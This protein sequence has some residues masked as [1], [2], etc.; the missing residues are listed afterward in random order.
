M[1]V[2]RLWLQRYFE[3]ELPSIEALSDVL[4]FHAFEI[5]SIENDILD[6]KVTAN[7][8]HDCLSHRGI[9]KEL[10][11]ILKIPLIRDPLREKASFTSPTQSVSV[12]IED[13]A[14]ADRYIAA[15]I[16]GVHVA[17]SPQWL[18]NSLESIGQKSIN[19]VVDAT[20]FVMFDLGQPLH[21]F[22][23]EK[24]QAT[25]GA[26]AIGV[27]MAKEGE[28]I[29]ALDQK[30]YSLNPSIIVIADEN[31]G[32]SIGIAGV[33]GGMPA[34]ITEA[35]TNI[36]IESASFNGVSVRK[37]AQA[38][39]LRTDASSRFEQG[40]SPEL[41]AVGMRA[42]VDL[43]L[44]LAGGNVL[45]IVDSY[46][47][48]QQKTT[49]AI[50]AKHVQDILGRTGSEEQIADTLSRLD[51]SFTK[52]GDT[53]TVTPPFERLDLT[54][55]EDLVEE[56][57]RI[58]GYDAIPATL[59][60]KLATSPAISPTFFAAE[61][62]RERLV[63]EGYSEVCTSVFADF[64][65]R[66]V[67][68]KVDGVRQYLRTTLL[69]SLTEAYEK[70]LRNKDILGLPEIKLFE[71]G[72]VWKGGKETWMVGTADKS[73][74]KEIALKPSSN[75]PGNYGTLPLSNTTRYQSF[76]KYP[77]IVRDIAMW[78]LGDTQ[79]AT[80]LDIIRET[81][82]SLLV[83]REKFDEFK[84]DGKT[85]YAFRLVF[86]SFDTTL[87]DFDV[88]ERMISITAALQALGFEIR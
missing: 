11:A 53:F 60:P 81:A 61:A 14:P 88:H 84:K 66:V 1:K 41:C 74:A 13:D 26:Y 29:V 47:R 16:T 49:F 79:E 68:N 50:H 2:S 12:R 77:Y 4:T 5:E 24:L 39:K 25:N 38:L 55:A 72:I 80:I 6:V 44:E 35:T 10:S 54:I 40:L 3:K 69:P 15:H 75:L 33:K 43:I 42:V 19:N 20:N 46:S 8:G 34:S 82:G 70:N 58:I 59:L 48:V 86:Q 67:A 62:E 87:T 27:R 23:A 17:P 76:S 78:V 51:V 63:S 57:G 64:G 18:K 31:A 28:S 83:R 30:K 85:S 65:E 21:A 37:T 22:D 9:A 56:V 7:R 52:V 71:I 36:L 32:E 45:G 73:G